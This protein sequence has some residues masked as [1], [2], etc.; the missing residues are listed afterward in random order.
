MIIPGKTL[1]R[2]NAEITLR[3]DI[4]GNDAKEF[5]MELGSIFMVKAG[6]AK[7]NIVASKANV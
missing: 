2:K 6:N 7:I 1:V 3:R 5:H 4:N